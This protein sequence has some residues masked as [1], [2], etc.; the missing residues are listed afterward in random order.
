MSRSAETY[1]A[2][3]LAIFAF[4]AV[5][6]LFIGFEKVRHE[7]QGCEGRHMMFEN[8]NRVIYIVEEGTT[9]KAAVAD[10]I[11]ETRQAFWYKCPDGTFIV[12]DQP[13]TEHIPDRVMNNRRNVSI[14]NPV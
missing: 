3:L 7:R 14:S 8:G 2:I 5:L 1:M 9:R 11:I 6:G 10:T 4:A 12:P 13:N